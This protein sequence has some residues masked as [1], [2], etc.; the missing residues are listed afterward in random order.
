MSWLVVSDLDDTLLDR[1]YS[2]E[3]A[4]PAL[5][6]LRRRGIPLVLC[7]SKTAAETLAERER[8]GLSD[9]FIVENG[10]AI[11]DGAGRR[12]AALAPPLGPGLPG[13]RGFRE[14][15]D[16]E[17][18]RLTGLGLE[19]AA[20]ARAREFDEAFV[21]PPELEPRLPELAAARGLRV[22]RGGRFWHVHGD[23]DKGRAARRLRELY[24]G[25][26]M[27]A[28]GDGPNDLSLLREADVARAIRRPD[29]SVDPALAG[30]PASARPGPAG[31]NEAV[32]EVLTS[33]P[34]S[35]VSTSR[36]GLK[37]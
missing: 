20:R 27:L 6:E 32:L 22:S 25:R 5:A 28:L 31:W 15:S 29:G 16:D 21:C 8:L 24:P 10:A 13:T 3:A 4:T 19:A 1:A 12:V 34:D 23:V 7:T 30:F 36:P 26:R 2:F 14:M 9:P 33:E 37:C 17:V 18:A 11:H 35:N